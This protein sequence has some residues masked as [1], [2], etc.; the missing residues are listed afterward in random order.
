[1][2]GFLGGD[3]P[4]GPGPGDLGLLQLD[5]F[6]EGFACLFDLVE[7]ADACLSVLLTE[8]VHRASNQTFELVLA[9]ELSQSDVFIDLKVERVACAVLSQ[10]LNEVVLADEVDH[11]H[12]HKG[13][14]GDHE[15]RV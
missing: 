4:Q 12:L 14:H 8:K 2:G 10:H 6:S 7:E 11:G 9:D 3:E 1:M 15:D 13:F 5:H